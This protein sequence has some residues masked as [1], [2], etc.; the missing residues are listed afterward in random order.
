VSP[1]G[2]RVTIDS[3]INNL[4]PEHHPEL[5]TTLASVFAAV[6]PLFENVLTDLINPRSRRVHVS[7]N[8]DQL[9]PDRPNLSYKDPKYDEVMDAWNDNKHAVVNQD[10]SKSPFIP[11]QRAQMVTLKGRK[12]QVITKLANIELSPDKPDYMGASWHVEGM[13]NEH[14]VATAIWYYSFSNI[15]ESRLAFRTDVREPEDYEQN[16]F[17]GVQVLTSHCF[18]SSAVKF[19]C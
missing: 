7:M 19:K 9:Y 10:I 2:T 11:H 16:D 1:D 14:I 12:L 4:H 3:Y 8:E 18:N 17:D 6:L 15:T 13:E 5:Y